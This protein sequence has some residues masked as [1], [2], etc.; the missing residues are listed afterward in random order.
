[1]PGTEV[2][3]KQTVLGGAAGIALLAF[4]LAYRFYPTSPHNEPVPPQPLPTVQGPVTPLAPLPYTVPN[5][6]VVATPRLPIT[7]PAPAT[8]TPPEE[9]SAPA[10]PPPK[11]IAALLKSADK[12]LAADHLIEPKDNNALALYQ[13]VLAQDKDNKAAQEGIEKI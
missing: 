7:T 10:T 8:G 4:A 12:A 6:P 3:R 9:P 11:A 13:Q 1:M 2:V 5:E